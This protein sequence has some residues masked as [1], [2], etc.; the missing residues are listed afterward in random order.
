MR[1]SLARLG[2]LPSFRLET[3]YIALREPLYITPI[4]SPIS[5]ARDK[6]SLSSLKKGFL[7]FRHQYLLQIVFKLPY[8]LLIESPAHLEGLS[9]TSST[10]IDKMLPDLRVVKKINCLTSISSMGSPWPIFVDGDFLGFSF[11]IH[12][13]SDLQLFYRDSLPSSSLIDIISL[14]PLQ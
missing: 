7:D 14:P 1:L 6:A 4:E 8:S 11:D 2:S 9:S 12:C 10:H 3:P 5:S 13:L